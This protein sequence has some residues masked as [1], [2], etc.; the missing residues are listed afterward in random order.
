MRKLSLFELFFYG[1]AIALI[2]WI[3]TALWQRT[4]DAER[5]YADPNCR[6]V[7]R[8]PEQRIREGGALHR[9]AKVVF[10]CDGLLYELDDTRAPE[11]SSDDR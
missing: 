1:C 2:L 5:F 7:G 8:T 6:V 3:V 11:G 10:D 4:H 9:P